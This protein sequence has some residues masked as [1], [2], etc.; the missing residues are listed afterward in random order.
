MHATSVAEVSP[1]VARIVT[2]AQDHVGDGERQLVGAFIRRYLRNADDDDL[3]RRPADDVLGEC[4]AHW[5]LGYERRPGESKVRV[6]NP[7]AETTGWYSPHSVVLIINDDLPFLVDTARL[8]VARQRVGTHLMIHPM[9]RVKR[10]E[11]GL[12][13]EFPD[14]GGQLEAWT[15]MEIDRSDDALGTALAAD[16]V[17]GYGLVARAVAD[18]EAMRD[19]AVHLAAALDVSGDP[20]A[21]QAAS[22]L[23]WMA[24]QRFVFLGAAVYHPTD[25]GLE[26]AGRGRVS[27]PPG[28]SAPALEQGSGLG[29]PIDRFAVQRVL[30]GGQW[31]GIARTLEESPVLRAARLVVVTVRRPNADGSPG[32][33]EHCFVGLFSAAA[34]RESVT[35][36]PVIQD[37][38]DYVLARAG[39]ASMSHTG[40]ELRTALEAFPRDDLFEI[41]ADQLYDVMMG[42]VTVEERRQ[43]RVFAF[44]EP[45]D[46]M[47]TALVF[48]PQTRFTNEAAADVAELVCQAA[49]GESQ[50][51]DTSI[52]GGDLARLRISVRRQAPDQTLPPTLALA[53]QI[54]TMTRT[55]T[56]RLQHEIVSIIGERDGLR[57]LRRYAPLVPPAYQAVTAPATAV[58]DLRY[59]DAVD[60]DDDLET[61]L[62]P[63]LDGKMR[64]KLYRLGEPIT[65]SAM[66]PLLE[67][68][69]MIV[70][71]QR[72][73]ELALSEQQ[74]QWIYD[75]GVQLPDGVALDEDRKAEVQ[76]VF[77][78]LFRGEVENDGLNRLVLLAG[79]TGR[80][81]AIVRTYVKYLRQIG[82]QYS[83]ATI[84]ATLAR[85][86]ML[87][88]HLASLFAMRFAPPVLAGDGPADAG[89]QDVVR[90]QIVELLDAVP[91]LDDDRIGRTLLQLIDATLRT[92]AY[93]PAGDV[94]GGSF[95]PV[96]ALKLDPIRVPELPLPRPMFEIF[97]YSP[98]VEG[99][100]LR[101]GRIAR[102]GL[103]WSD[104]REDFRTE[105][106]GLMKAQMVKN[107]VIVPVGAKGGF[108]V[109]RPPADPEG[110]PAEVVAAYREFVAGLLDI[111]DNIAV[112]ED[113]T[114]IVVPPPS[115]MR[116]DGDDPYLVVAADKGTATFSDIANSVSADYGFWLGDAFAS[117]GS[118]GYDH[119]AMAITARGAWESVRSHA[120]VIG[121]NADRDELTVVGIGDMSGDVFGN[122]LLRSPH[123]RLLAAFDHRHI[124]V[125]P[126]PD[127]AVSFAERQRLFSLPR[128]SWA[129]YNPSLI[130]AGGGV[131]RRSAKH[132]ELSPQ[133]CRALGVDAVSLTPN[134]LVTA[135]LKAPVDLLWNGGIGTYVKA[136]T[137]TNA[138]VG[139]RAN[140]AVRI[141]GADLRC[142]IV[143]EGGNLGCTQRGRIEFA[144]NG[145][146]INTDAIDNSAGVDCSDHE[147]NIKILLDSLMSAGDLTA[148]Q[149]NELL[150]TMKDEVGEMVLDDNRAQ[151]LALA[152]ARQQAAPMVD[153]HAR[154]IH[155]LEAE[156][157]INRTI[158]FL[159]TDKQLADRQASG[160]GLTTPELAVMLA[161]TKTADIAEI[162]G[163]ASLV[164]DPY[165][166]PDLH[167]YFPREIRQRF[168]TAIVT[169]RL[170]NEILLT[171]LVNQM[172]NRQGTSFDHR[173]TEETGAFTADV[174]RAWIVARDV[175][176]MS[177]IWH[178][179]EAL[180]KTISLDAQ[181][182]LFLDLRRMVE[183]SV[184]WLLRHR[185][186]P[187]PFAATVA[188]FGEGIAGLMQRLGPLVRGPLA[189]QTYAIAAERVVLGV[190]SEL[191]ERSAIWPLMHTGFDLVELARRHRCPVEHAAAAYWDL[192]E[193][194]DVTWLW[195]AIGSLA[196]IDRWQSH[197]R[198][199]VR[200]D[201]LAALAEL[202]D[203]VLSIGG[204][205]E[206]WTHVNERVV[207]RVRTVFQEIRRNGVFDLTTVTVALRQLQ[208][209]V[210]S[211]AP[212]T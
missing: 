156:G 46:L 120:R 174:L 61:S 50:S 167:Q 172:V 8:V 26:P 133:A 193:Q 114:D 210:L 145:G 65:L 107:A 19:Q 95:R 37:K 71:D 117:G 173:M 109:K 112:D 87:A 208:N 42:I 179:I 113:G 116:Y 77:E 196:R 102:G 88:I 188:E 66:L 104:R 83:Q 212:P 168:P 56:E 171:Q 85:L 138:D 169:H 189:D 98:R 152:I 206:R 44:N 30:A 177:S 99:V 124:F 108:V 207:K 105:I 81:V 40:R 1:G 141:N 165:L 134:E 144:L 148:I 72:P 93:R 100:H 94:A 36:S 178:E 101:G 123:V 15:L 140:D 54:E 201:L 41:D 25:S 211:T 64:F 43:V 9:L 186:P 91:S 2:L 119:K 55:W 103:R 57:L 29:I 60:A 97:V 132:I 164:D 20:M 78:S 31:V 13:V 51:F 161:Y 52:D 80:Q 67:N 131:F 73:F 175:F 180:G 17:A 3:Q 146:L 63:T 70:I 170:R 92:N 197:A 53:G 18:R 160:R 69:G 183:R 12:I 7:D 159:P 58:V 47:M 68:L 74:S 200:D 5:R 166:I 187:I 22:L 151:T 121:R 184:M 24:R 149:R 27:A 118:V 194:L 6:I 202:T 154:Y 150:A 21:Q 59:L 115:V 76:R 185:R 162:G 195:N 10:D 49:G 62:Q 32:N 110:L 143:G 163:V 48:L 199:A 190:P 75:V 38:A 84:E 11:N 34:Y 129:D 147:V 125:D 137:E 82:F 35:A 203:D 209:L 79:L 45:G 191:A 106:L 198:A 139:D 90:R 23:T 135:I 142:R 127:P 14:R 4:L 157:W 126:S 86:P 158:E 176:A 33:A 122:G 155:A 153:V 39:F 192:L 128:S 181:I 204:S 205:V 16:M 96:I 182:V 89:Q 130:A 111:T 28:S 136:S